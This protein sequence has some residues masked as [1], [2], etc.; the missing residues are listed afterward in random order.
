MFRWISVVTCPD[1]LQIFACYIFCFLSPEFVLLSFVPMDN[2]NQLGVKSKFHWMPSFRICE[3]I[4][5]ILVIHQ[6]GMNGCTLGDLSSFFV[7][8]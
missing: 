2:E 3:F 1:Q 7:L 5:R 6:S 8:I 4:G